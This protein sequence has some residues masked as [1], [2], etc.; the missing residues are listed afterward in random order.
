MKLY[1]TPGACSMAAHIVLNEANADFAIEK[2]DLA[3]KTTETGADFTEVT[4]KGAVPALDLGNGEVL[5]EGAAI[6]QYLADRF[7][8]ADL[9]PANGT[10]ART[11]LQEMLTYISSEV[12]K[13]FGP[14]FWPNSSD[15]IKGAFRGLLEKKFAHLNDV[16]ADGRAWLTG[17]KFTVADAYF[18]VMTAWAGHH[19][20]S[21]DA[22]P[23][24]GA[25]AGKIA[26]REKVL[27]TLKAEGL[28]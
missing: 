23:N 21:L 16:L 1:Y 15:E 22:W 10:L 2:V 25:L 12:H 6:L 26:G 20:I 13:S 3:A 9:A 28:A 17:D 24:V 19:K 5:T 4:S 18:F 11:R 7:P 8:D 27:Q 14:L